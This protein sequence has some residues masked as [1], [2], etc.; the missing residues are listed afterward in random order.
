MISWLNHNQGAALFRVSAV[1]GLIALGALFQAIRASQKATRAAEQANA[2]TALATRAQVGALLVVF[3]T[4]TTESG[5]R[6][7]RLSFTVENIGPAPAQEVQAH[8]LVGQERVGEEQGVSWIAGKAQATEGAGSTRTPFA[9][10]VPDRFMVERDGQWVAEPRPV[11][12]VRYRD[13]VDEHE[14]RSLPPK[15]RPRIHVF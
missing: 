10:S 15:A 9:F 7:A 8:L 5:P 1:G 14:A 3:G 13:V 2:Q 4:G 11:C 6:G 12:V